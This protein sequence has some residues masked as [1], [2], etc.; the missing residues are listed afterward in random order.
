MD[1]ED[2]VEPVLLS[3]QHAAYF[4]APHGR[5]EVVEASQ[6]L[7][8]GLFIFRFPGQIEQDIDVPQLPVDPRPG[9]EGRLDPV[10]LSQNVFRPLRLFPEGRLGRLLFE[11]CQ[12]PRQSV[13]V[14]DNLAG[15]PPV[16]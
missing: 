7:F 3:S 11:F 12:A 6:D 5:C 2:G 13:D 8:K 16:F 4:L 9:L 15:F 14:K 10:L 1:G